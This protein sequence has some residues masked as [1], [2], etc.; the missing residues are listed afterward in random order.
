VGLF[1]RLPSE[2]VY[3]TLAVVQRTGV[4]ADTFRAWERRYG[5]PNP[6]RTAGNQ[7]RYSDRD[8]A[9]I[10]WLRDQTN[11]GLTISQAVDLFR[12]RDQREPAVESRSSDL[13]VSTDSKMTRF[14][15]GIVE[16][17]IAFDA[18]AASRVLEDAL[19]LLPVEQVCL[20]ILQPVMYE[21]GRRWDRDEI[22]ISAEHFATSFVIRR[23]G[24]L[25]NQAEQ[26]P[27]RGLVI[28][29][30]PEGELHEAGLLLTSLI[31]TRRGINILYLGANLP[32]DD[33]ITTV[34]RLKPELVLLSASTPAS[35]ERLALATGEIR[36]RCGST[37][38]CPA[39]G[40][41][42]GVF[43]D[44]PDLRAGIDGA[45]L[46]NSADEAANL[47]EHLLSTRQGTDA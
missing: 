22:G 28:A 44:N 1:S 35:A 18:S 11:S 9:T 30:C 24:A 46:G 21:I 16:A 8:I 33:L 13:P 4:P 14:V 25:Y 47:V 2:P 7:R 5:I 23:L 42:G 20:D 26:V 29:A 36:A 15:E 27:G 12:L 31:L 38:D 40:Y 6:D 34:R 10:A 45:F 17:L 32:T 37:D 3:N 19:A 43:I 41:G 39:I